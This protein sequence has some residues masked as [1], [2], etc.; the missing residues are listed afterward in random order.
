M[1]SF[2]SIFVID[3]GH[4]YTPR[5]LR[6]GCNSFDILCVS[7]CVSVCPF[8]YPGRTDGRT[9]LNFGMEVKWKDI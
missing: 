7:V 5:L 4:I 6:D 2:L 8:R 1:P 3:S 9:Y